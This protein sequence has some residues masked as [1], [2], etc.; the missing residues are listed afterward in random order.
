MAKNHSE[1]T[2]ASNHD[3]TYTLGRTSHETT[4][5]IEQSRIYGESTQRFCKRAGITQGMRVLEIGSGAGDVAL[6][7]AELVGPTG[8][9]VGVDVNATIL[10]TARQR[11]ADAGTRNVEFIAG[12]ARTLDFPGKFDAIVGR[13]VLMYMADPRKAFAKLMTHVKPGG[14]AAF[15][16]PEYTLYPA[17]IH[18]DTPLINQLIAWILDVFEHSGAHLDMGIGLYRAFVDAGLPPPAMHLESPIGAAKVW[19]G[20]RYMVT[21]FQSLLPLLEEYGLATAEQVGLDTLAARLR[22]E[23]LASKRPFLLPLHVTAHAMLPI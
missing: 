6:T 7:L 14:I 8:R 5:L 15:Q 13:F 18:P 21:I 11:A 4:R 9:V 17:F 3:A 23:V 20:Y 2:Q 1:N 16:E 10:D 12:D 19:A 22:Q